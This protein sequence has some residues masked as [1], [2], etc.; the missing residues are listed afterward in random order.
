KPMAT[1]KL[2]AGIAVCE[3]ARQVTPSNRVVGRDLTQLQQG[4][5][6]PDGPRSLSEDLSRLNYP[7]DAG[8]CRL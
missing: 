4:L 5:T 1:K 3:L 7:A 2:E 6:Q 8:I